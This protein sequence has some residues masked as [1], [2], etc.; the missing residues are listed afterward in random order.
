[1]AIVF[2]ANTG[3]VVALPDK[4]A[5]GS[6]SLVEAEPNIT[7]SGEKSIITRVGISCAGNYQFLHTIGNDVYIYVFGDRM[8]EVTLHGISFQGD[9][10]GGGGGIR[11][12]NPSPTLGSPASGKHGFEFLYEWYK[13]NRIAARMSPVKVTIGTGTTFTGFVTS[14]TGDVQDTLRRTIQFTITIALLPEKEQFLMGINS[15]PVTVNT[16]GG[17]PGGIV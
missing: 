16:T 6:F 15:T 7:Y 4:V 14:L 10:K 11:G 2:Q 5:Q 9:C 13:K 3:K 8:G 12:V 17:I 1:M